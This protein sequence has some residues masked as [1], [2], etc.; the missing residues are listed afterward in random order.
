MAYLLVDGENFKGKVEEICKESLKIPCPKWHTFNFP[1]LF[2][3]ALST[4]KI[5]KVTFYFAKINEHEDTLKKSRRLIQEQRSLK[6]A[7][8]SYGYKVELAGNVRGHKDSQGKL[9]FKE[10]G[11]DVRIAVDMLCLSFDKI[12]E[13]IILCSSDSDL[14]P[15]IRESRRR[16]ISITY[17]GFEANPNKGI[18]Y[19]TNKTILFRDAEIQKSIPLTLL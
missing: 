17:L 5:D 3:S 12:T 8:E 11:V 6:T 19:T 2:L 13:E 14:Q 15:A 18:S 9:V 1:S 10:K 4:Y 7:L 16:Q